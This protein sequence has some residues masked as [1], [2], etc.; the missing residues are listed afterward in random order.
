[1][2]DNQQTPSRQKAVIY[3]RVSSKEQEKEGY[4][5]PSQLKLLNKYAADNGLQVVQEY[6]DVETAKKSGRAGFAEMIQFLKKE[7]K[8]RN[9]APCRTVL[10]E[11]TDR[12]YRNLKD[13][14]ILDDLSLE[15][16]F[17]K[18]NVSISRDSRS[19]EKF[20]HGIKVLMAKNYIDNLSEETRK[21][22]LEKAEQGIYPSYAPLGYVNVKCGDKNFVQPDPEL[23]PQ[24]RQLFEWY[25]TGNYSLLDLTRKA[26]QEGFAFRKSGKQVPKSVVHKILKNPMYY[27]EFRW[28]GKMYKGSH[29]P[30]I[31]RELFD[32]VQETMAEKGRR[33]TK[34]Q[35]HNWPFQGLLS[36]GHCGCALV[37]EIKKKKYVYYHCT[38]N[39]G[40]CQEKWVR[41]EEV[42]RQF[43]QAISA[44][45][46]D[47][48]VLDWVIAALKESH[49]DEKKY[50]DGKIAALQAQYDKLQNRLDAMYDD[51]LDGN[52]DQEFY[53][54]KSAAWKK[55]QDEI[56]RKLERHQTANR[57]Y[58]D[59]GIKLLELA[60]RAVILYE[61]QTNQKK[62][63]IINFVC[64]NSTWKDGRLQPNYRQP[65][66]ILAEKSLAYRQKK[67]VSPEKNGPGLFWLPGPDS[68]QR[69]SG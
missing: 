27:G 15:I 59:E 55:E 11:K 7:A 34:Q 2:N 16:H 64:S 3:A 19:S 47:D 12:L 49:A 13:W 36:C 54:R 50:H 26:Q 14:V 28:A 40:K 62:R 43:G 60:Q 52:I 25:A 42:A 5:I 4:S 45:K 57:A 44:L 9:T 32:R 51:K 48:E 37:A 65:F 68:N 67:A 56:I 10:V 23:G 61:K 69:Q 20:M 41:E 35:K 29:E 22:M 21:G 46:L 38:G 58:L 24:V 66:D 31:S 17:I 53:D 8:S 39:K 63:R 30:L 33:N 6:V 18:E 1:M